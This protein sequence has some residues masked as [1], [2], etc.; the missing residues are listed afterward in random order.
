MADAATAGVED[1][2]SVCVESA[3]G[4]VTVRVRLDGDRPGQVFLPFHYAD[5]AANEL[6]MDRWDPVSK[7]PE[8]KGGTVQ[9]RVV[10]A[11]VEPVA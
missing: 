4:S 2:T 5:E 6:T 9:V 11:H 8:F 1:G 10:R 3:R 7:Q